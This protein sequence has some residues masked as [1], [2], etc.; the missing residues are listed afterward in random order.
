MK[1]SL[2]HDAEA[3]AERIRALTPERVAAT[4]AIADELLAAVTAQVI[5]HQDIVPP[6]IEAFKFD[7]TFRAAWSH[8]QA[9][10]GRELARIVSSDAFFPAL[11]T[12]LARFVLTNCILADI[13]VEAV[14]TAARRALLLDLTQSG[15]TSVSAEKLDFLCILG[16]QCFLNEFAFWEE[17]DERVWVDLL[18]DSL[19]L[20]RD[21]GVAFLPHLLA[22][23]GCYRPLASLDLPATVVA[24]LRQGP[25]GA[26]VTRTITEPL[27]EREIAANIPVLTPIRDEIS[28][29]V[30]Q[31]YE[32][33][34]YPRWTRVHRQKP[35]PPEAITGFWP[36]IDAAAFG[37]VQSPRILIAGCG[38]G[39]NIVHFAGSF[40]DARTVAVDLSKSSLAYAKRQID[41]LGMEVEFGQADILELPA[42]GR[43]FDIISCSGVLHHMADPGAG[44]RA[45]AKCLRPGGLLHL[46]VYSFSIRDS[47]E[48]ARRFIA[49]R[50]YTT[51]A[52]DI[53]RFRRDVMKL[54]MKGEKLPSGVTRI[55][56][57]TDFFT[58]SMCRDLTFHV[59][60]RSYTFMQ[61]Y[62]LAAEGGL[63]IV[64]LPADRRYTTSAQWNPHQ[65]AETNIKRFAE[66]DR[67]K[68]LGSPM[69]HV[70]LQ[71]P[72]A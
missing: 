71:K 50:G 17:P 67:Q 15:V 2:E 14:L 25:L 19:I 11:T 30:R 70:L 58:L 49:R 46:S 45:L 29:A 24:A 35:A 9:D 31:Q 36:H 1:F 18:Y 52:H 59:Q 68:L 16:Q 10:E 61:L 33:N 5:D 72:R 40:R 69:H 60:E 23:F 21:E 13:T 22:L 42:L 26:L 28:H 3:W 66:L 56:T 41:T 43:E 39:S 44:L 4:P 38:T 55:V 62:Q 65:S 8:A 47:V 63:P 53:R 34:P 27:L 7:A 64:D 20:S 51:A 6:A 48:Q 54:A 37:H 57:I 12:P 32:E